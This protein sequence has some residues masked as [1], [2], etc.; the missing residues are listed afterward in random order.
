MVMF[1]NI[2]APEIVL[3]ASLLSFFVLTNFPQGLISIFVAHVMFNIEF[4][5]MNGARAISGVPSRDRGGRTT[6][7]PCSAQHGQRIASRSPSRWAR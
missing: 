5:A 1:L 4:V 3:G 7:R 6:C 2:A